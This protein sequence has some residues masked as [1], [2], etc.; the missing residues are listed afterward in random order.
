MRRLTHW[1]NYLLKHRLV[2]LTLTFVITFIPVIGVLGILFAGLVTIRKGILEGAIFTFAAT[3]PYCI[4]R[5]Y[6]PS[7]E[8]ITPAFIWLTIGVGALS[9]VLTWVFVVM[10]RRGMNWSAVLQVAAL[11]G[12]LVISVVHLAYPNVSDWW[13]DQLQFLNMQVQSSVNSVS[14]IKNNMDP[15]AVKEAQQQ[16]INSAKLIATGAVVGVTLLIA[17]MQVVLACWWNAIVFNRGSLQRGLHNIRLSGLAGV[18]F[19]LSL[20]FSYWGN[21]VVLDIMPILYLLFCAAGLSL[22]HY[23]F[24]MM[25]T[26][27]V[28]FWLC[29][30][31]ITLIFAV[32]ASIVVV[33]TIALLD[34]WL[35]LR[36]RFKKAD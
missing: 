2:A 30:M 5:V 25:T 23:F 4:L 17:F 8:A 15:D 31:Y 3:L 7:S 24:E 32:P 14:S 36:K 35:D 20:L 18:L 33:A 13:A 12:V 27:V 28:W 34:I 26:P 6:M 10:M 19:M 9:N 11:M 16:A 21:T 1:T 22:L 29:L